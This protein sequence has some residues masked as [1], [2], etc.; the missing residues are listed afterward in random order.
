MIKIIK[1]GSI[2]EAKCKYCGCLFSFEEEDVRAKIT[3]YT[4]GSLGNTTVGKYIICPQC[5]KEVI[6]EEVR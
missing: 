2:Q 1:P 6:S 4:G 5:K 3:V